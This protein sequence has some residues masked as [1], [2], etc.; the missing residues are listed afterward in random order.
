MS[1]CRHASSP[2]RASA[3]LAV[4]FL[5]ASCTGSI[6]GDSP[7]G[8]GTGKGGSSNGGSGAWGGNGGGG[9]PDIG[10]PP[11]SFCTNVDPGPSPL[12]LMTRVEYAN[13]IRDLMGGMASVTM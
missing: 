8:P 1:S 3:F 12:R 11:A 13:T 4:A 6:G 9:G 10:P 2:V 5:G 7:A